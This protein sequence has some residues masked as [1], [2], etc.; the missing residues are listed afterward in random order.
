MQ[1][2]RLPIHNAG[3]SASQSVGCLGKHVMKLDVPSAIHPTAQAWGVVNIASE[4]LEAL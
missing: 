3:C 1:G 2:Y 4:A